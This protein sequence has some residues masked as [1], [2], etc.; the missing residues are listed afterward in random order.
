MIYGRIDSNKIRVY[1]DILVFPSFSR[2]YIGQFWFL[3]ISPH[4]HLN[5]ELPTPH[6]FSPTSISEGTRNQSTVSLLEGISPHVF[7]RDERKE[8][9]RN[10]MHL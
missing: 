7:I 5:K 3:E 4:L 9:F 2:R 1:Q 10:S 8:T 6:K